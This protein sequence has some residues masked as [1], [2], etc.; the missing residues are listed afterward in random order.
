MKHRTELL[1]IL[2]GPQW[3]SGP[4]TTWVFR[5]YTW[6]FRP[7]EHTLRLNSILELLPDRLCTIVSRRRYCCRCVSC[8]DSSFFQTFLCKR[9]PFFCQLRR[10][11]TRIRRRR[12]CFQTFFGRPFFVKLPCC[13]RRWCNRQK[14]HCG[15]D[16]KVIARMPVVRERLLTVFAAF[17]H[18]YEGLACVWTGGVCAYD[19]QN[20][21]CS[22]YTGTNV[23]RHWELRKAQIRTGYFIAQHQ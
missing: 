2:I 17:L 14:C 3:P 12:C 15:Y 20:C 18:G 4:F 22:V 9:R 13:R 21:V 8:L 5:N 23:L 7:T 1:C 19:Q 11:L 10:S 6:Y 16:C